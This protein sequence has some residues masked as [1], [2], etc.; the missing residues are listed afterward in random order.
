LELGEKLVATQLEQAQLNL[1][2]TEVLAPVD[3]RIVKDQAELDSY[4]QRGSALIMLEDTEKI[5]V[6]CNV[7]MDQLYWIF[8]QAEAS[9]DP[10]LN[11]T[12]TL[13]QLPSTPV[14]IGFRIAGRE[15]VLYEWQGVLDRV[16]GAGFDPQSRTV[17]CRILVDD[18]NQVTV[19]GTASD[20]V[21][22]GP[23]SLVRGMFVEVQLHAKPAARLLLV[24]KL[25]VRPG[26]LVWAYRP[27][28]SLLAS[29]EKAEA[30]PVVK[31]DVVLAAKQQLANDRIAN[32]KPEEWEVGRLE[33]LKEMQVIGP[34][35]TEPNEKSETSDDFWICE[36][37]GE[38]LQAGM[39]V[40]VS[41][42]PGVRG[43]GTDQI[44]VQVKQ[45]NL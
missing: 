27:D 44:R 35:R 28:A 2:R 31:S 17:P 14:T 23:P 39:F 15:S 33:I 45:T 43:D 41:P 1:A 29:A 19:R 36:V 8:N 26:N 6:A 38:E 3:G 25:G 11:S 32:I 18:P 21:R 24:P 22:T 42:L 12:H 20:Q 13:F 34:Y 16:E 40:I 30:P 10:L 7:R 4:V 5:E 9:A 37:N